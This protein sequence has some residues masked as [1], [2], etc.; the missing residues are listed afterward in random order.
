VELL[1]KTGAPL[2]QY[3]AALRTSIRSDNEFQTSQ[4]H[5][6]AEAKQVLQSAR[7]EDNQSRCLF[8]GSATGC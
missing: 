7:N 2:D 4:A 3:A 1:R 5:F 6:T 8:I